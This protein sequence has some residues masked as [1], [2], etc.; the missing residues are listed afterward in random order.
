[1]SGQLLAMTIRLP[2]TQAAALST[3]ATVDGTTVVDVIRVAID[4]HIALRRRDETFQ[5]NLRK[6]IEQESGL[7]ESK[8]DPREC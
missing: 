4:E 7:L 3:V 5:R 1:V 6:H 2:A 8:T